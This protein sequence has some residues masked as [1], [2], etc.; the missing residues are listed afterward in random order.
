[1]PPTRGSG[2]E[3][4]MAQKTPFTMSGP[5]YPSLPG[6]DNT[7]EALLALVVRRE[8]SALAAQ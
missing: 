2:A 5:A 3:E 4:P 7:D 8:Q 1:M 6:D